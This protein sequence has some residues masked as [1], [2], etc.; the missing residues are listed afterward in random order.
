MEAGLTNP[1]QCHYIS[2]ILRGTRRV[3]GQGVVSKLPITPRILADIFSLLDF[4]H[5]ARHSLLGSL[6]RRMFYFLQ[7][8][9]FV[10]TFPGLF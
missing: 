9:E 4:F 5:L 10:G 6:S 2:S 3:L 1:V 8:I 7:E